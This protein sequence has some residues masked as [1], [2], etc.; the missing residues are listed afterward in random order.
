MKNRCSVVEAVDLK[1]GIG[2]KV[3]S[4]PNW[5]RTKGLC[6][7]HYMA[8]WRYGS[9]QGAKAGIRQGKCTH[10]GNPMQVFREGQKY[11]SRCWPMSVVRKEQLAR[12][13]KKWRTRHNLEGGD[14]TT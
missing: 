10:C 9:A 8:K 3:I 7:R 13:S 12:A 5:A 11:H 6:H 2:S 4:C 1:G 14:K